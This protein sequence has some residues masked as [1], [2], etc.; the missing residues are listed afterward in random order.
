MCFTLS[1]M[2]NETY[3]EFPEGKELQERR[4]PAAKDTW[5]GTCIRFRCALNWV[6]LCGCF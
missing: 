5:Q 3:H 6:L 2:S 1:F 4:L